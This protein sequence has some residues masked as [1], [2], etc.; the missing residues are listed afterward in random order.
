MQVTFGILLLTIGI[1]VMMWILYSIIYLMT[2]PQDVQVLAQFISLDERAM[3]RISPDA[4]IQL[5]GGVFYAVG[6]FLYVVVLGIAGSL[7]KVLLSTGTRLLAPDI[8]PLLSRLRE[9]KVFKEFG[10]HRMG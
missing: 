8:T 6:F 7:T 10:S 2:S 4:T 5:P 1:V 3:I 9:V